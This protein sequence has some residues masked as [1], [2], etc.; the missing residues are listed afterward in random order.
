[1]I[2]RRSLLIALTVSIT[3]S[4]MAQ[5]SADQAPLQPVLNAG[6]NVLAFDWPA[7]M[8]GTGE[9]EE[10]PTGVTVFRFDRRVHAAVDV[11]G[12]GPGTV[13]TDYLRIGYEVPEVDSV[14]FS[15]GSTSGTS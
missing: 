9:Y 10:G 13:N 7:V 11:R 5:A 14:V 12:G 4:G 2:V 3:L 1:M 15:G 6:D 8:V